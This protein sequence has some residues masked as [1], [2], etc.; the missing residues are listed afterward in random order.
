MAV[1]HR[2]VP[3]VIV[4][5]ATGR[6]STGACSVV[7][8]AVLVARAGVVLVGIVQDDE[9]RLRL[10]ATT[11]AELVAREELPLLGLNAALALLLL[12]LVVAGRPL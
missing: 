4:V 3:A 6:R 2:V 7:A 11:A 10:G 9:L 8:A 5:V 12:P 1:E